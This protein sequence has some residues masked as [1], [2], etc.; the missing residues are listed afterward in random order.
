MFVKILL[1]NFY[2]CINSIW[3]TSLAMGDIDIEKKVEYKI[4]R[5]SEAERDMGRC[6]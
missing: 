2:K 1:C 4:K 5:K 6:R 3:K